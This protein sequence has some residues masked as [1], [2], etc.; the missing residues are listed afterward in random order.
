MDADA[1]PV[2]EILVEQAKRRAIAVL[3]V[4]DTSHRIADG[5]SD[6]AVVDKARDSADLFLINRMNPGDLVVTQD[7]G[8]AA[9]ALGKGGRAL[10]PSGLEYT[11]ENMD[12]LL[13][14][15]HLAQKVRRASG[16]AG[17]I[18]RRRREDDEAFLR[19]LCRLPDEDENT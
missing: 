7:F 1:C 12:K 16:R 17:K 18:K 13:F 11:A 6:V 19:A 15:R 8:V 5:Y 2:K 3:M 4:C 10:S 14:E 9:L